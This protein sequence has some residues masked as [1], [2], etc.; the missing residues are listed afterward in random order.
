MSVLLNVLLG[1]VEIKCNF[2]HMMFP[3]MLDTQAPELEV[4]R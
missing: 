2:P 4:P 3:E 1:G